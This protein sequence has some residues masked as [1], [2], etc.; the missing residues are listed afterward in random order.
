MFAQAIR[1]SHHAQ[2]RM[3]QR[4]IQ[5]EA[6]GCIFQHAD[7]ESSV[8]NGCTRLWLSRRKRDLLGKQGVSASVL[9]KTDN[10]ALIVGGDECVVTA[11]HGTGSKKRHIR[12]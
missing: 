8:G 4:G 3:R 12:R 11:Y 2:R 7:R 5:T 10:V 1:Y 9:E 6:V